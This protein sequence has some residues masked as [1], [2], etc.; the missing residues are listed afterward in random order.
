MRFIREK[1][2]Q[3]EEP[4]FFALRGEKNRMVC[5]MGQNGMEA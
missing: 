1:S 4:H 5:L 2:S 3:S